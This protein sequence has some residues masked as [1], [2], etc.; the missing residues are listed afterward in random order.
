MRNRATLP[1]SLSLLL[2]VG[3]ARP[4]A[5]A[6]E[7]VLILDNSA[8]MSD[9]SKLTTT[10]P[11]GTTTTQT[12]PP[13]DP[14]R[15]AVIATL[16]FRGFL[17]ADDRL[18][19][20]TFDFS[21]GKVGG[22]EVLPNDIAAIRDLVFDQPTPFTGPLGQARQIFAQSALPR[23]VLLLVTDGAPGAEDPLTA[24]QA[25]QLLGIGGPVPFEVLS[26]GLATD[27]AIVQAQSDF[28]SPLGRLEQ[29]RSPT[30]LVSGFTRAYAESIRS[31]PD[32]GTLAPGDKIA[33]RAPKYVSEVLVALATVDRTGVFE[34]SL[35]GGGRKIDPLDGGDSGCKPPRTP[36]HAYQ[37][38]K[39][40]K[41]PQG[42]EEWT[43]SLPRGGGPVAYGIILR[44]DLGAEIVSMSEA[45]VGEEKEVIARLTWQGQGF[46]DP[47]FF[48]ADDFQATLVLGGV[49]APLTL[50]PDDGSFAG[51]IA[52][53]QPGP[54]TMVARFSNRWL[55][56]TAERPFEAE[57]WLPLTVVVKP[58]P[59]DFGRW[60]GAR[61][62]S[63]R[64]VDLDFTGSVNADKVAL[65]MLG[66]GLPSGFAIEPPAV[67]PIA[68]DRARVCL[69]ASGCSAGGE[70]PAGAVLVIRGKDPHYHP[71][72]VEVPIAYGVG[73]TPFL[74]C[75]WR[76]L[77]AILAAIALAIVIY[78]F[79]SPHDFDREEV[80]RLAS[81]E[82]GLARAAGRRLREL[83]GGRRGF[84][85]DARVA[86]DGSGAAVKPGAA[87]SLILKATKNDMV[88]EGK[89]TLEHKDPRTRKWA[90]V[91]AGDGLLYL[92]RGTV[93][94]VGEI[95]IRIG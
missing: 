25:K 91:D 81:K 37:V 63:Q 73:K 9:G 47:A 59:I 90:P 14:H 89:T 62:D 79:V 94:R 95:Y 64:C 6:T 8:S 24:D 88:V 21:S 49:E 13:A 38:F 76:V 55:T 2:V 57:A 74:V 20:L 11:D 36:C 93:Y 56:V 82:Q 54:Q 4:V 48:T 72:A 69:V 1:L 42:E 61:T 39:A 45:K 65:E 84:Y 5:A 87:A 60:T 50:R 46:N 15:L 3:L 66:K 71:E 51:K 33:F 85:R 41:S 78:G 17:D 27:P 23:K 31:R 53:A 40:K 77:A 83:P 35:D 19:I 12:L 67:G 58:S 44:Y 26:L 52:V 92:R 10:Q 18:T 75:W 28:L 34:A 16:I 43:L 70:A 22:Y 30:E 86:F 7:W 80:I 29:I 68:G 32:T